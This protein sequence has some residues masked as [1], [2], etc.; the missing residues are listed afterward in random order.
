MRLSKSQYIRGLQCHKSLWCYR[1]ARELIPEIP[2]GLQ[3]IFDQGHR[4]G[5]LACERFPKGEMIAEDYRHREEAVASTK[6]ALAAGKRI[7]YEAAVIHDGVLVRPDILV[8]KGEKGWNL[9]EV[10]SSTGVKEVY[11]NDLAIQ[12]YVLEGSGLKINKAILM[13]INNKYT[14]KGKI[15]L[16]KLFTL[17]DVTE[18]IESYEAGIKKKV[19]EMHAVLKKKK[20]P[21]IEIGSH[22]T[23]P[24]PC[25]FMGECWSHI[26]KNSVYDLVGVRAAKLE[27][28]HEDGILR[29]ADIPNDYPLSKAQE[30]QRRVT[31][32]KKP[33]I[34]RKAIKE[35]LDEAVYPLYHLDF[36]AVNC[37]VP[38]YDGLKP[39]Q[40]VAF[41]ASVHIQ[42]K[43]SGKVKHLEF[44][45]DPAIDPR[46][47]M[48]KFLTS[49][50]GP[51]GSVVAYNSAFEGGRLKEMAKDFPASSQE[52]LSIKERLWD[53]ATPFRKG[54][55]VH[56]KFGG[57]WSIK[58]VLPALVPG[59]SY[60]GLEIGDGGVASQ[61]Y[62]ELMDGRISGAAAKKTLAALRVYCGQDTLAMVKLLDVL[63]QSTAT[64]KT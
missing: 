50:I 4:V 64:T 29:I 55:Y 56:P 8:K 11:L 46:P 31:K 20:A 44:L 25:E 59:M 22:C 17:A 2:P 57:S 51:T 42:A 1:H 15:D 6:K 21:A 35:F 39:F 63:Y 54:F 47:G 24:Y 36:E 62:L 10:K 49:T 23:S 27:E 52:L 41:Q 7:L 14:R 58:V 37:A 28:F 12:K 26:P 33:I 32:S 38:P 18:D 48:V 9:I 5:E 61:S 16:H 30:L 60:E 45:S 3:A 53:I 19:K 34:D 43:R 13:H 40:Q